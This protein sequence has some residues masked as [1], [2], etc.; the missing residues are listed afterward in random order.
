MKEKIVLNKEKFLSVIN[1]FDSTQDFEITELKNIP[2]LKVKSASLDDQIRARELSS[3]SF[4]KAMFE[5]NKKENNFHPK[6]V[7]EIDIFHK[8]VIEPEFTMEEVIK[9]SK[10]YPEL[11]NKVCAFALGIKPNF[12]SLED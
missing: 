11:I 5:K 8:C 12:D 7:F 9:V 10:K 6:T 2:I 1:N 4:V 3:S